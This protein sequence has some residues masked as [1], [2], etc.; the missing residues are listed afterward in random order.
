M[1]TKTIQFTNKDGVMLSGK[2]SLPPTG[3]AAHFAIFAHCFTCNKSL[4]TVRNVSSVLNKKGFGVLQFDFTGLGESEG[5][6]SNTN[7]SGN[8]DDIISAAKYLEK[9]YASPLLL[10]GHSLGGAAVIFAADEIDSVEAVTTIGAPSNP[11]HVSHLF[12][13]SMDEIKRNGKATVNIG[14]RDFT[15]KQQFI[16]DIANKSLTKVIKKLHKSILIFHSPQDKIVGI[17]NAAELYGA[18]HHPKSFISLDGADHLLMKD[19]NDAIYVGDLIGS[20]VKR[21]IK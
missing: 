13:D 4:R 9:N 6:F 20:W 10:I 1:T 5:E 8:V 14:G 12:K 3:Q 15:I 7:F 17:E 18:A 11:E 19:R 21:Y 2:I 16:D